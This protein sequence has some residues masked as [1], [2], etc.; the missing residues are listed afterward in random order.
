MQILLLEI[1]KIL[2]WRILL[3][4]AFVNLILY[5]FLIDFNIKHFPNGRPSLDSYRIGA[6]MVKNYGPVMDVSEKGDFKKKYEEEVQK[7]DEFIQSYDDFNKVGVQSYEDFV[8]MDRNNEAQM[9]LRDKIVFEEEVDLFWEL[10]ERER[11]LEFHQDQEMIIE[12]EINRADSIGQKHLVELKKTGQFDLYPEVSLMN[13]KDIIMNI[14]IAVLISVVLVI[15]PI[16]LSD[17]TRNIVDLQYTSNIGRS[18]FKKKLIAGLISTFVV[19][20]GLLAIYLCLYSLNNPSIFFEVPVNSF[21][22]GVSWYN[23][24]F[25][26]YIVLSTIAI[27]VLGS[28]LTFVSLGVSNL[29]PSYI[30][31]IGIQV[32]IILALLLFGLKYLLNLIISM[33]LPIWLVPACYIALNIIVIGSIVF[34]WKREKKLDIVL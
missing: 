6:E 5:Y 31:L 2:N 20:T 3:V 7:A 8:N 25:F 30:A 10:Q 29:V 22:G 4:V 27:Y 26:Q 23:L 32:P 1:R 13:F 11:L 14:A 34:L 24:T 28:L 12:N 16:F 17:R 18:I 15:S 9:K 33:W 19:I 21:I